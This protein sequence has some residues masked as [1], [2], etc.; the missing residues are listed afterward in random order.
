MIKCV[1]CQYYVPNNKGYEYCCFY[2]YDIDRIIL[3][4][5]CKWLEK[6]EK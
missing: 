1:N 3:L 5:M 6:E 2:C 4:S